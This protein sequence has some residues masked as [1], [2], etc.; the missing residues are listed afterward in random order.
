MNEPAA[1]RE[2]LAL[3]ELERAAKRIAFAHRPKMI[4]S[5][6]SDNRDQI[7]KRARRLRRRYS[8]GVA[9][10]DQ[11]SGRARRGVMMDHREI[12]RQP[13]QLGRGRHDIAPRYLPDGP[14]RQIIKMKTGR[15]PLEFREAP[16]GN[17]RLERA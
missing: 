14:F 16:A 11:T 10:I 5:V 2:R 1:L 12:E 7:E 9:A 13:R 15:A 8:N 6:P 4:A 3:F 17:G